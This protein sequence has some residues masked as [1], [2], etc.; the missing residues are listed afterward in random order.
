MARQGYTQGLQDSQTQDAHPGTELIA[1]AAS[2]SFQG[3]HARKHLLLTGGA[4]DVGAATFVQV[5]HFLVRSVHVVA[6]AVDS[7]QCQLP[8]SSELYGMLMAKWLQICM[9]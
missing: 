5:D 6:A 4:G 3:C 9:M 1:T 8:Q 7:S 2:Q